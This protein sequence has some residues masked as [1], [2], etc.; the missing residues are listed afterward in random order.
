MT[1][2]W[3]GFLPVNAKGASLITGQGAKT[4]HDLRL[5]APPPTPPKKQH[6]N[7][8]SNIVTNSIQTLKTKRNLSGQKSQRTGTTQLNIQLE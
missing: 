2:H 8:R 5:T 6:K 4:P 1:V 3:L 7:N